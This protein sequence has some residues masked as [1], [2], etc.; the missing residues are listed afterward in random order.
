MTLGNLASVNLMI[1][2]FEAARDALEQTIA[3]EEN[4]TFYANLGIAHYY[5]GNF[6]EAVAAHRRSVELAPSSSGGWLGLADA[7]YFADEPVAA[8]SAYRTVIDLSRLQLAVN[9]EDVESM[10]FLAWSSAMTGSFDTATT[11]IDRAVELDP[12]DSYSHY[13]RALVLLRLGDPDGALGAIEDAINNGY[14]LAMLAAEPILKELQR[15]S[16]FAG[17]LTQAGV[18]GAE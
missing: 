6:P 5:L 11:L 16:R 15:D 2:D 3:I 14:P 9:P 7:L 18:K 12:A 17:L 13:F 4:D 1:G 10:T 8:E